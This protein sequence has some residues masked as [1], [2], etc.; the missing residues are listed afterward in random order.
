MKTRIIFAALVVFACANLY[1]Q[2][3]GGRILRGIGEGAARGA[4]E[5]AID[6][7]ISGDTDVEMTREDEYYLGRAVAA[8]ILSTYKTY[9]G[10]PA[11]TNYLNSICRAIVENS[12]TPGAYSVYNGYHVAILDSD[13]VNAF[14]TP[15]GHIFVTR[16]LISAAKTEDALAGVVA[17]EVAHIQLQHGLEAIKKDSSLSSRIKR[18]AAGGA[19]RGAASQVPV[20]NLLS[21]NLGKAASNYARTLI[22]NGYSRDQE[23]AADKTGMSLMA[24]AGYNPQGLIDM[25]RELGVIQGRSSG[26]FTKTHPTPAAR[27]TEAQKYVS[28]FRVADTSSARQ[29]RFNAVAR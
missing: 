4:A 29:A 10:N 21:D 20:V 22:N 17:H 26:G 13:E 27:I 23:F 1:S 28:S 25:L 9:D 3:L 11:L 16:G 5:T 14:A 19:A 18:G 6:A 12:L 2:G 7:A 24:S 15:G 8:T